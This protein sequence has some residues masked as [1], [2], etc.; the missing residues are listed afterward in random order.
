MLEPSEFLGRACDALTKVRHAK[1][2]AAMS[3]LEAADLGDP[4]MP[5][6]WVD[7]RSTSSDAFSYMAEKRISALAMEA[8]GYDLT[9]WTFGQDERGWWYAGRGGIRITR[10]DAGR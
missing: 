3:L 5:R 9:G 1:P 8:K 4:P 6:R 10:D 7:R 2:S